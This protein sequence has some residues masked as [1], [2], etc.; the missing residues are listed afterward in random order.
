MWNACGKSQACTSHGVLWLLCIQPRG[1]L[2][3]SQSAVICRA[4]AI[5]AEINIKEK[6]NIIDGIDDTTA[7]S[8]PQ[9]TCIWMPTLKCV[10][11]AYRRDCIVKLRRLNTHTHTHRHTNIHAS[12]ITQ[13]GQMNSLYSCDASMTQKG[14]QKALPSL[15]LSTHQIPVAHFDSPAEHPFSTSDPSYWNT[16][17]HTSCVHQQTVMHV[18]WC[19][20]CLVMADAAC[21]VWPMH[22][23]WQENLLCPA[24]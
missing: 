9:Y 13:S 3:S 16:H 1:T 18:Q 23:F 14:L 21:T 8:H 15:L 22:N 24:C 11:L 20:V 7:A 19:C 12:S 6:C 10:Y 4:S 17:H 2:Q 5:S